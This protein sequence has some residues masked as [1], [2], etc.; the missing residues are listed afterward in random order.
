MQQDVLH[1]LGIETSSGTFYFLK[2]KK[3]VYA[4][5]AI[6]LC[7]QNFR[8]NLKVN[9]LRTRFSYTFLRVGNILMLEE[10]NK[11]EEYCWE[12][13]VNRLCFLLYY[14]YI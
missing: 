3:Q 11:M 8:C 9:F 2:E 6:S 14:L 13:V 10:A 12:E 5:M 4:G 1:L 7:L